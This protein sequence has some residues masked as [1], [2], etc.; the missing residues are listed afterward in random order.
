MKKLIL[1]ITILLCTA[2]LAACAGQNP[3]EAIIGRWICRD[4]T[5]PH[6]WMC[7]LEFREDGTFVDMDG[8]IGMF[9][10]EGRQLELFFPQFQYSITVN[11]RVSRTRLTITEGRSRLIL[12]RT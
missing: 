1:A 9:F 6:I 12:Q 5:Q 2:F 4:S 11:F 10:I 8:D 7:E 3:E